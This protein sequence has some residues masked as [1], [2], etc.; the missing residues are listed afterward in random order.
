MAQRFYEG[1]AASVAAASGAPYATIHTGANL[2]AAI[3]EMGI[4]LNAATASSVELI[5]PNN[6]PTA[7]TSVLGQAQD[8]AQAA[9]SVNLDTAWSTAPTIGSNVPLRKVLLPGTIGSGVIWTWPS[10]AGLIVPVSSY[11]VLWNFGA[12]A[13]SVLNFYVVWEE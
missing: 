1:G 2:V 11:L 8:T 12:G 10:G 4:F 3:R 6:S 9:S 13:G 7:S 5:R